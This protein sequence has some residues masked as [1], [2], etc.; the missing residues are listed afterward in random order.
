M[1]ARS[2]LTRS[3]GEMLR[4]PSSFQV[5]PRKWLRRL[6]AGNNYSAFSASP[7]RSFGVLLCTGSKTRGKPSRSG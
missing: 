4:L 7:R 1:I 2:Q 6:R 3:P 5:Q